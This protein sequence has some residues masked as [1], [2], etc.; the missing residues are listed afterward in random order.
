MKVSGFSII[1]NGNKLGYCYLESIQSVLPLCDEFVIA[2]G[3]SDDSTRESIV[4]LNSPKI[5]II[6]TVWDDE[7]RKN[8]T[9]LAQQ[10]NIAKDACTGDWLFYIQGDEVLHEKYL[11][12]VRENM[13]T[14]KNDGSIEGLLFNY[15]HFY[16]SYS[17]VGGARKWYRQEI[18]V[19]KNLPEIRSYKDAQGFRKRNGQ[20]VRVKR[21]AA[22]IYHY[23]WCRP[24][25][26]QQQKQ[27]A[28]QRLYH[29]DT[30]IKHHVR[31]ADAFDYTTVQK[32][33]PFEGTHPQV[34]LAKVEAEN[35]EF[36]YDPARVKINLKDRFIFW[37][38]RTF[39]FR[40]WENKNFKEV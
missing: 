33:I 9:I 26:E 3:N 10:T 19:L 8:G 40:P 15:K 23:G 34:M 28:F 14:Y 13:L 4:A 39:G 21:I 12:V 20:K 18:R 35:W 7:L 38:E 37:C 32:L 16:G 11:E 30:W 5:K 36:H 25:K 27:Y 22:E 1:R 29:D 24:P 31:D 17:Y 6:D 2:L